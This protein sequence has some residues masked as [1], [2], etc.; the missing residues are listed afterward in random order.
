MVGTTRTPKAQGSASQPINI[1]STESTPASQSTREYT[2]LYFPESPTML[3]KTANNRKR[4]HAGLQAIA[5]NTNNG[6]SSTSPSAQFPEPRIPGVRPLGQYPEQAQASLTPP[7]PDP[8]RSLGHIDPRYVSVE[9]SSDE[10]AATD[11]GRIDPRYVSVESSS[12]EGAA[13]D[14]NDNSAIAVTRP[15]RNSSLIMEVHSDAPTTYQASSPVIIISDSEEEPEIL[16]PHPRLDADAIYQLN[17][18]FGV[19]G[20]RSP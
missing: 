14:A 1:S 9:S 12:D 4:P 11:L 18:L 2:P 5:R 3:S 13:T 8:S 16:W 19:P 15:G 6:A 7:P 10:G 20:F 17:R